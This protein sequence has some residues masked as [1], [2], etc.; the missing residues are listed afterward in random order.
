VVLGPGDLY[1]SIIPNL[2]VTGVP[3]VLAATQ[4]TR[5]Y[6][7]NPMTKLGETDDFKV[8]DFVGEIIRY[9]GGPSLDWVM[10]NTQE[11]SLEVRKAYLAEEAVPVVPD[12]EL[13]RRQVPGVLAARLS[14]NQ[15]PP[16]RDQKRVAEVVVRIAEVGR[17]QG[18][19]VRNGSL[20]AAAR[21]NH[22]PPVA[23]EVSDNY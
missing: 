23:S 7:C 17:V 6:V 9:M 10:V 21:I 2:L 12:L 5:I 15:I 14:N 19:S 1:T 3:Q 16:K 8:S 11:V 22:W 20:A 13:V 18:A 4:A